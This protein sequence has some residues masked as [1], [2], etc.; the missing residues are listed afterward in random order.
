MSLQ[1]T[2][3][4]Y[5][6]REQRSS[7][8]FTSLL[9]EIGILLDE[10]STTIDNTKYYSD[11]R[12]IPLN[13][14]DNYA[15]MFGI[16]FP[17]NISE[18]TK[19]LL[20][21]DIVKIHQTN[22]TEKSL[23]FLFNIIGL[24]IRIDYIWA[25]N[26][27]TDKILA[28]EQPNPFVFQDTSSS[29]DWAKGY[30]ESSSTDATSGITTDTYVSRIIDTTRVNQYDSGSISW[31]TTQAISSV[32]I[33]KTDVYFEDFKSRL[34]NWSL[35]SYLITSIK[36]GQF[37]LTTPNTTV[38]TQYGNLFDHNFKDYRRLSINADVSSQQDNFGLLVGGVYIKQVGGS[39]QALVKQYSTDTY[40]TYTT[41]TQSFTT[42][43]PYWNIEVNTDDTIDFYAG[44][45]LIFS[46]LPRT[47]DTIQVYTDAAVN[48]TLVLN[49]LYIAYSTGDFNW[50]PVTNSGSNVTLFSPNESTLNKAILCRKAVDST[51][52]TTPSSYQ[53]SF[54]LK[55][56]GYDYEN[57]KYV[58]VK[59]GTDITYERLQILGEEYPVAHRSTNNKVVKTPYVRITVTKEDYNLFTSDYVDPNTGK[60]YSYTD[61]ERY[62]ITQE[63]INYFMNE[64]RPANVV[65]TEISTPFS[66]SDILNF[67]PQDGGITFTLFASV[68]SYDGTVNYGMDTDRYVLGEN[69]TG[70]NF[71]GSN[72]HINNTPAD[73]TVNR[74]YPIGTTGLQEY[75]PTRE[76]AKVKVVVPA[77]AQIRVYGSKTDRINLAKGNFTTELIGSAAGETKLFDV[78][79]YF[80]TMINIVTP[81][82]TGEIDVTVTETT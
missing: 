10:I 66:L 37:N 23:R 47:E 42:F 58:T 41:K 7:A 39:Y 65:I 73:V 43:S 34:N 68:W 54:D 71:G 51:A 36:D 59:D 30:I 31:D 69:Y 33:A 4:D 40:Y 9:D 15:E 35:S 27:H 63:V 1:D 22:G 21:R 50:T 6:P 2:L 49:N 3:K 62:K 80:A 5:L 70:F 28:Y 46:G 77:D 18:A 56:S 24:N 79:G 20:A 16:N 76:I 78:V 75:V 12:K 44:G 26:P 48:T 13:E 67:I 64:G 32:E 25:V 57:G 81:S 17:R 8:P 74:V 61:T 60:I 45:R 11:F 19:R 82:T 14:L 29:D 53:V 72:I 38:R 52:Q 55:G